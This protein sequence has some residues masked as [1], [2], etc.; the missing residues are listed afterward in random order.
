MNDAGEEVANESS[1]ETLCVCIEVEGDSDGLRSRTIVG[2]KIPRTRVRWSSGTDVN[3]TAN[4]FQT[5]L[6]AVRCCSEM[7]LSLT[8]GA[9]FAMYSINAG[10]RNLALWR[11]IRLPELEAAMRVLAQ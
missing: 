3:S 7:E 5:S 4:A 9:I 10:R 8:L 11:N 1:C 2:R 6:I